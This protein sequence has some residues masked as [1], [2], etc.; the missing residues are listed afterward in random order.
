MAWLTSW[1]G[2]AYAHNTVQNQLA[3]HQSYFPP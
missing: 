1:T 2:S 3:A